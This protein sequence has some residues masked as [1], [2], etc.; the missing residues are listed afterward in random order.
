MT[1]MIFECSPAA[2]KVSAMAFRLLPAQTQIDSAILNNGHSRRDLCQQIVSPLEGAQMHAHC[3]ARLSRISLFHCFQD[4]FV[5]ATGQ[6]L[7]PGK[8]AL[9]RINS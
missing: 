1:G 3:A 9:L 5:L 7:I 6:R 2:E 8:S 4:T